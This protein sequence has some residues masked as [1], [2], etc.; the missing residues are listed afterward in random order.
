MRWVLLIGIL[1]VLTT[2]VSALEIDK[3]NAVY[4]LVDDKA[5]VEV[6][7]I[8]SEE[9]TGEFNLSLPEDYT[10]LTVYLD[11]S[12]K[13][14][15]GMLENVTAI[16]YNYITQDVIDKTNFLMNLQLGYAVKEMEIKLVLPS[17][18]LLKKPLHKQGG[19]IYPKPTETDTDGRSLIF[20]WAD[21]D[22]EQ[23]EEIAIFAQIEPKKDYRGWIAL[24]ILLLVLFPVIYFAYPRKIK[25]VKK[26]EKHLKEDEEQIVTIL[27]RKEGE[28]EQGTLRVITGFSKAHLSRLLKE[29]EE[30]KVVHKE[31]RGKKNIVFLK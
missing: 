30:R 18:A 16:K 15:D 7:I 13:E 14:F 27:E 9:I 2:S 24:I 28:C 31:K 11:D 1:L 26:T 3:Y 6:E 17:G 5:V 25:Q 19:S 8:F 29:L 12:Q 23:D 4:N 21:K 10:A 22:V 20:I